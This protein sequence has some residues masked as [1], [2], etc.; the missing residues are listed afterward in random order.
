MSRMRPWP[1]SGCRC[2]C[3]STMKRSSASRP[4][5][6]P[7]EQEASPVKLFG[8]GSREAEARGEPGQEPEKMAPAIP[9][10][11]VAISA[12]LPAFV[13]RGTSGKAGPLQR[14][15]LVAVF[16]LVVVIFSV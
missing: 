6:E 2:R 9:G 8:A 1:G 5:S 12:R 3:L 14:Y 10:G 13:Q 16:V 7:S 4:G 15:A 11:L